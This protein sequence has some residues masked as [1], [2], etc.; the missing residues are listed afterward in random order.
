MV[1]YTVDLKINTNIENLNILLLSPIFHK[2]LYNIYFIS[3]FL[4]II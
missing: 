1:A 3:K 2:N 4:N